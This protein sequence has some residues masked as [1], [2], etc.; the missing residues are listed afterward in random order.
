[1]TTQDL[2]ETT[3]KS[4]IESGVSTRTIVCALHNVCCHGDA[5]IEGGEDVTEENLERLF[6]GFEISLEA[7]GSMEV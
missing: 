6:D 4:W 2:L 1:M 5:M 7:A 3:I